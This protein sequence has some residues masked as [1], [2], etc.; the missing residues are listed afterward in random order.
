VQWA[1]E[2][3]DTLSLADRP[4]GELSGGEQQRVLLA[5]ALAQETPVLLL[6]EPTAHLDLRHQVALLDL[7]FALADGQGLC[8]LMALHDLNLAA[9]YA[10]RVA[11]LV[12]GQLRA[13]G[14]PDQVLTS[15][16][17][18]EIYQLPLHVISHPDFGCPLILPDGQRG[19]DKSN[20]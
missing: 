3:T 19:Q 11:L 13:Q 20:L 12:E 1:L 14:T 7:V 2:H 5:R 6:D 8:V 18:S 10:S 15:A 16:R 9:L 17:L 4:I